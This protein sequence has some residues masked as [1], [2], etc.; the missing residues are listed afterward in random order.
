MT[1]IFSIIHLICFH[2]VTLG[3]LFPIYSSVAKK[4]RRTCVHVRW[5]RSD[6]FHVVAYAPLHLIILNMH[7]KCVI[8]EGRDHNVFCGFNHKELDEMFVKY[9]QDFFS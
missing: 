8:P 4:Y 6:S 2:A 3:F 9:L 5:K 1:C 7:G